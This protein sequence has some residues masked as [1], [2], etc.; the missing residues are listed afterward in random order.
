MRFALM[1]IAAVAAVLSTSALAQ[2]PRIVW[3]R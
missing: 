2:A 1:V 3:K